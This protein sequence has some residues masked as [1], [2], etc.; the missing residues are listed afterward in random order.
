MPS[1]QSWLFCEPDIEVESVSDGEGGAAGGGD[2]EDHL[3]VR[4]HGVDVFDPS[5]GEVRS[6]NTDG[7]AVWFIDT[8][9]NGE[10]F[11]VRYAYFLGADDPYKSN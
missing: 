6:D 2:A 8:N 10:S 1:V 3:R 11:F 7:I 4:I 5:S 9:Y